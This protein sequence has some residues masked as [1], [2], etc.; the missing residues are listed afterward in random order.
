MFSMGCSR[1]VYGTIVSTRNK[2]Q[3]NAA[4]L[5]LVGA[6][7][8]GLFLLRRRVAWLFCLFFASC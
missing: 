7:D 1:M 8:D 2:I 3:S 6:D 4:L 5:T